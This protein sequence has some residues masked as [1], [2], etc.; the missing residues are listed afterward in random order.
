MVRPWPEQPD[1]V[2]R[3]YRLDTWE[4]V[5]FSAINTY[6]AI[7][8]IISFQIASGCG[9]WKYHFNAH[10]FCAMS[11]KKTDPPGATYGN[12]S[13][14]IGYFLQDIRSV[15]NALGLLMH[16]DAKSTISTLSY[17]YFM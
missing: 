15:N 17:Y 8:T 10:A 14:R 1:R 12:I 13:F 11:S 16:K 4:V 9:Q 7:L 2:L 5:R 3:P 6:N